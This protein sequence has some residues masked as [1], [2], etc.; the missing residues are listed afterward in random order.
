VNFHF[1]SNNNDDNNKA[2][3]NEERALI[4]AKNGLAG[5]GALSDH[6][7]EKGHGWAESDYEITYNHGRG[8]QFYRFRNFMLRN[9]GVENPAV[10]INPHRTDQPMMVYFSESSSTKAHRSYTFEIEQAALNHVLEIRSTELGLPPVEIQSHSFKKFTVQEQALMVSQAAVY[11]TAC[12]GGAV[13]ATFLP[14]GASLIVAFPETGGIE[15]NK[16]SNKPARLDWDYLNNL[17]YLRVH[18]LPQAHSSHDRSKPADI[19]SFVDLVLHEIQVV[20]KERVRR[21]EQ[22]Q[23]Q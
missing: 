16:N 6:G 23:E 7:S 9:I 22:Y 20:Y 21:W 17:S 13:T 18:W 5:I 8:G 3:D 1:N 15:N 12:G 19:A 10:P 4:C 14:R 2:K 11:V